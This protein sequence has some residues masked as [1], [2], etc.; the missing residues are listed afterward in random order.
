MA[1]VKYMSFQQ[2]F[3]PLD[4]YCSDFSEVLHLNFIKTNIQ[5]FL[6]FFFLQCIPSLLSEYLMPLHVVL[7]THIFLYVMHHFGNK[8]Y[9]HTE[10]E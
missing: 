4:D 5:S 8:L 1:A 2:Q 9:P 10:A 6:E 3:L 7:F